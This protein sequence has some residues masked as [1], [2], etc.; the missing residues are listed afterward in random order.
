MAAINIRADAFFTDGI[1]LDKFRVDIGPGDDDLYRVCFP[2][3]SFACSIGAP[4]TSAGVFSS[5]ASAK[6]Y[7]VSSHSAVMVSAINILRGTSDSAGSMIEH[8]S[9]RL[10]QFLDAKQPTITPGSHIDAAAT[11]APSN[12]PTNLNVVTT[13]LGSLTS[14]VNS[15]NSGQNAIANKYND[16]ATKVNLLFTHLEAQGL[17]LVS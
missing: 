2:M 14:Q 7:Y 9:T 16:L 13:L 10:K 1:S 5:V 17:Q 8:I 6:N 11:D 12:A 4:D 3:A 15:T